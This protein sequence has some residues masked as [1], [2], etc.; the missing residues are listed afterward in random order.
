MLRN[1]KC[2]LLVDVDCTE[3]TGYDFVTDEDQEVLEIVTGG[4]QIEDGRVLDKE[5]ARKAFCVFLDG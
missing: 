2:D 5:K 4:K 1:M 3:E